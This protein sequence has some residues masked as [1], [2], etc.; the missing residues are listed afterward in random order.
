MKCEYV[1]R[2]SPFYFAIV[3]IAAVFLVFYLVMLAVLALKRHL[4]PIETG[5]PKM[6]A[7]MVVVRAPACALRVWSSCSS[8]A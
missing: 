7:S 1:P 3:S 8:N 4:T 6:L 2:D 5:Q